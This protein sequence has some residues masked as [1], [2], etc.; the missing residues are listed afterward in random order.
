MAT[1][2][3]IRDIAETAGFYG[4]DSWWKSAIP[5]FQK[6]IKDITKREAKVDKITDLTEQHKQMHV[7]MH[8]VLLLLLDDFI[9]QTETTPAQTKIINLMKWSHEQTIKPTV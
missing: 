9:E 6:I 4:V 1:D 8:K 7:Q 5:M 2:K 3:E